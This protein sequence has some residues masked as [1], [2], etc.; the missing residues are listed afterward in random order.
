MQRIEDLRLVVNEL[1]AALIQVI[2]ARDVLSLRYDA[3]PGGL[4]VR[5]TGRTGMPVRLDPVVVDVLALLA[6]AWSLDHE[7]GVQRFD[8]LLRPA[9]VT[10]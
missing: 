9:E 5:G 7:R 4:R 6:D 8:V 10:R 3:E 1:C 2:P